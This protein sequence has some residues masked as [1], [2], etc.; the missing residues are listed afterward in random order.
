MFEF[1]KRLFRSVPLPL[2]PPPSRLMQVGGKLVE[3]STWPEEVVRQIQANYLMPSLKEAYLIRVDLSAGC[4]EGHTTTDR[5]GV[6]SSKGDLTKKFVDELH[7][8]RM[9]VSCK[10]CGKP[11]R[12]LGRRI[13]WQ[14]DIGNWDGAI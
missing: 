4:P 2:S 1:I 5:V 11:A 3:T 12:I 13:A 6:F 10:E 9:M 14:G 7:R 8:M